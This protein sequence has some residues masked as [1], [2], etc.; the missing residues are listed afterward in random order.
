MLKCFSRSYFKLTS[1]KSINCRKGCFCV[2]IDERWSKTKVRKRKITSPIILS[3]HFYIYVCLYRKHDM[4]HWWTA[5]CVVI[6]PNDIISNGFK[7][8][9]SVRQAQRC[10]AWNLDLFKFQNDVVWFHDSV[11]CSAL[12]IYILF[13]AFYMLLVYEV[14]VKLNFK[15]F[16][17]QDKLL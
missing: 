2:M 9:P 12:A 11:E 1:S 17:Q 16:Q 13:H 14:A 5:L 7:Q 3:P 6:K 8:T 15:N 4:H 10:L